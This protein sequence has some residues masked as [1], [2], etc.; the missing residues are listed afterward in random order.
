VILQYDTLLPHKPPLL[1]P[2]GKLLELTSNHRGRWIP[3]YHQA[4]GACSK[5]PSMRQRVS[6][7]TFN[8]SNSVR[9]VEPPQD[10]DTQHFLREI[11][12]AGCLTLVGTTND[13]SQQR[14]TAPS[15]FSSARNGVRTGPRSM[16]ISLTETI[17]RTS[18]PDPSPLRSVVE[19]INKPDMSSFENACH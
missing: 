5:T 19:G 2:T 10:A 7:G 16:W 13:T 8:T 15:V 18:Q 17:Q 4:V 6:Q 11:P 3:L 12:E 14:S 1:S 9:E